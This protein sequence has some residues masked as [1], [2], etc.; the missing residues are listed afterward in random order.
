MTDAEIRAS[1]GHVYQ[2]IMKL[3][4]LHVAQVAMDLATRS[5]NQADL[6]AASAELFKGLDEAL[7]LLHEVIIDDEPKP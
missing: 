2:V 1:F 6:H 5:G 7:E 3:F 4:D